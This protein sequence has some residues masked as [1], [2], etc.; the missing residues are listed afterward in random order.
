M[1][2]RMKWSEYC[3]DDELLLGV[4]GL[5]VDRRKSEGNIRN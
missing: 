4:A 5:G 1:K 2:K 3:I